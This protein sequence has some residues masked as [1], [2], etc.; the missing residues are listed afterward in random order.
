MSSPL[1]SETARI[2][3]AHSQ[4]PVTPEGKSASSQNSLRHGLTSK[5]VVLP[6]EDP[7]EFA[8]HRASYVQ[9]YRPQR[10]AETH[11]VETIAAAAWRLNRI[12]RIETVMLSDENADPFKTLG[13]IVRYENQLNRTQDLAIKRLEA[14]QHN[15]PARRNEPNESP[16]ASKQTPD[17]SE[18]DLT[19]A[20]REALTIPAPPQMPPAATPKAS[21]GAA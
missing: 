14:L 11:L 2:N 20:I 7:D 3:G 5:Q 12:M 16:N 19:D 8:R 15:R 4:G 13:L 18:L 21:G 17:L 10:E 6:G 9:I 1:K